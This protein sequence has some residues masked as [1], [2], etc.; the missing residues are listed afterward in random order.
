MSMFRK[1]YRQLTDA[2][3]DFVQAFKD[4]AEELNTLY[5][6]ARKELPIDPRQLAIATTNLE[7]S[8]MW[9]VKSVTG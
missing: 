7:Q 9:A 1:E 3:K 8:V 4:K 2:E 6:N 5:E